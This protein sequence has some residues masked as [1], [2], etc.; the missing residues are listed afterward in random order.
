MSRD[1]PSRRLV[2]VAL[3][4]APLAA[5]NETAGDFNPAA[6]PRARAPGVPVALVS[7]EG[8]PETVVSRLS[9][10]ISQQAARREITVVGVDGNP[11]YQVRGYISAHAEGGEGTFSWAFDVF[12]AQRR[13]ARRV[14]GEERIRAGGDATPDGLW[15]GVTDAHVTAAAARATDDLAEF[16]AAAPAP[17]V[18]QQRGGAAARRAASLLAGS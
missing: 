4:A 12:D 15:N 18:A 10:A 11:R 1:L 14:S 2:L 5:C 6:P 16:L 3:A 7:L 9:L 8:G 17:P 13:R